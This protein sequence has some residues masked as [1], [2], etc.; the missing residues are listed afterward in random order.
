[1][2]LWFW[3]WIITFVAFLLMW[4]KENYWKTMTAITLYIITIEMN[5]DFVAPT[6]EHVG[7]VLKILQD[8]GIL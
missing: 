6:K 8:K 5:I 3:L 7:R 2:N 1:M 4:V